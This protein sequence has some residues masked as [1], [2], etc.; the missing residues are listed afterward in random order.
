MQPLLDALRNRDIILFVGAGVSMNVDLPSWS[1]L[2][3]EMA[4]RV[5]YDPDI[6]SQ[7]GDHLT[8]AEYYVLQHKSL[9]KLRSWMDTEWHSEKKRK[10]VEE[11]EIHKMLVGLPCDIIYTTNYDRYLEW[12]CEAQDRAYTKVTNVGDLVH[13]DDQKLEIIKF[14]GDFDDDQSIVLTESSY[15]E[16]LSFESP[17]DIKLRADVL[18]KTILFLGY[19]LSDINMRLLFFKL[20]KL[21]E[22]SPYANA[23]PNSYIFLTRPNPV[24]EAVLKSRGIEPII[25]PTDDPREGLKAFLADLHSRLE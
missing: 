7:L 16:R 9:G 17:L 6:F 18:G 2:V 10:E 22:S 15:F 25:S 4:T 20:H 5:G 1:K 24:Q 12:A 23:R 19:S 21:W 11:S 8:L 13:I 14:H 3:D